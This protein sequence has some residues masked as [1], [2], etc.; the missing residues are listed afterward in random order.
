MIFIYAALGGFVGGFLRWGLAQLFPGKRATL[1]ANTLACFVGG[2]VV[3]QNLPHLY[4]VLLI[5]GF[6][7]ALS[8]WSTLAKEVGTLLKKRQ[9]TL[10]M[11][12]LAL[13]FGL[14]FLAVLLAQQL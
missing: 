10:G 3:A 1:A 4:T 8:T 2:V 12:Y 14:G 9:W 6:C 13:T 11:G 5:A 7:G